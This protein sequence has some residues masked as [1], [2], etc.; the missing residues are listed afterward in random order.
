[1]KLLVAIVQSEDAGRLCRRLT[2][3]GYAVTQMNTAGGFLARGNVTVLLGLEDDQVEPVMAIFR[4]TCHTR[5]SYINAMPWGADAAHFSLSAPAP[6]EVEIGGATVFTFPV[7]RLV[8]VSTTPAASDDRVDQALAAGRGDTSMDML[9]AIVQSEDADE[10]VH[11][12]IAAGYRLTR[13]TT[14]GGFLR[15][16]NATLL[17][18]AEHGRVDEAIAVIRANTRAR[19]EPT[20]SESGMPAYSATVFVLEASNFIRI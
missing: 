4:S 14:A 13:L 19:T 18:G 9:V 7:E 5:R 3:K 15:R 6:L 10:V 17:V 20:P 8:R 2:G 1:M 12:L 16:G 11:A